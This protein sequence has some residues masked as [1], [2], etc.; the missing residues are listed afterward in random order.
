MKRANSGLT[1]IRQDHVQAFLRTL[2]T[3]D[4]ITQESLDALP[5]TKTREYVRGLLVEHGIIVTRD[6]YLVRYTA[7]SNEAVE[8]LVHAPDKAIVVRYVRWQHLRRMQQMDEVTIGTFLR[9]KQT[10][11]VA[12]DFLNWLHHEGVLFADVRQAH[13]D[14]WINTGPST[15]KIANRFL[16]WAIKTRLVKPD[17]TIAPHRRGTAE[18]L[19][20]SAQ[21]A[22]LERV[23]HTD[24][25]A[26]RER[27]A[28]TLVLVF[29][30]QVRDIVTLTW[31]RVR[32]ED[33]LVTIRM[34]GFDIDLPAPLD[35]PWRQ[36]AAHSPNMQTAAHPHSS[37]VF[38]GTKPGYHVNP[39]H[40]RNRLK[41]YFSAR[42]ARLGTLHELSKL[43]PIPVIADAL[44]YRPQTIEAHAK[45]SASAYAR[46][47]ASIRSE[48][49]PD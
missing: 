24:E 37:W 42:A 31:D 26:P 46:Y 13:L 12:I 49:Q 5:K 32:I 21:G 34:G 36:L 22:A 41:Q 23:V 28:A 1:W 43:G 44:G 10:V 20:A 16:R 17:L 6:D 45:D 29:G 48:D 47:V 14:E 25:L 30:Q 19:D 18:R 3:S 38:P 15:R 27:I 11:T 8:R 2:A 40:M 33:G 4:T 7:W 35:E 39:S 9:S